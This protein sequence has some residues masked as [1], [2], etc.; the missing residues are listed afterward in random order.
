MKD[1]RVYLLHVRDAIDRI[2]SYTAG[3]RAAFFADTRTQDAVVRNLE[4]IGEAG[5]TLEERPFTVAEARGAREAFITGAGN[6]V[7]PVVRV[8][9]AVLGDGAPGPVA[10]R[11]RALYIEKARRLAG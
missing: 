7:M 4:V 10:K 5:L 3:G 6:L 9:G 1:D 11:L 2:R 8:D